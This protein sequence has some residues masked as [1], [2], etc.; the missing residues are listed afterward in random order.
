MV[1]AFPFALMS[2][3]A[4]PIILFIGLTSLKA[5]AQAVSQPSALTTATDLA[6]KAKKGSGLRKTLLQ[7]TGMEQSV[8]SISKSIGETKGL[9]TETLPDLGLKI[10]KAKNAVS[11][12]SDKAKA[13]KT[14]YEGLP[15][16]K[17]YTKFGSGD[18]E[19][20][21]EFYVLRGDK[22][23]SSYVKEVF[24]YDQKNRRISGAVIKEKENAV[25]LHGP[26]KR[27]QGG[28]L[29]EEGFYYAGMKD[30]RWEKYDGKFM[31]IDKSRWYRGFPAEARIS[32]YD[33]THTKIKE[34]LPMEYGKLKG[35][36]YAFYENGL[37][38]EEGKYDNGVK[39]GR[40]TEFYS[41]TA[42]G[43][44]RR[45]LTQ[46]AADRWDTEFEPYVISE[47]DDRG[48][49]TYE[50]PKEKRVVADEETEN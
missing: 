49:L 41:T 3:Y 37:P 44:K 39:V 29:L 14:E 19:V 15:M 45:K 25:L 12:K 9:L 28:D 2:N 27:Y 26:Y 48:K 40:W 24:W 4:L 10:K 18:R 22:T 38:M 13:S 7:A 50:R 17:L 33:S 21:E 20:V 47:W 42:V 34:V 6:P 16:V 30:G 1:A 32:Y 43:R 8:E 5:N 36:Y 31:L 23:P 46:Y 11:G 35:N